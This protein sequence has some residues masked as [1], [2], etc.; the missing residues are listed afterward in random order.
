MD[1]F[2]LVPDVGVGLVEEGV[3]AGDTALRREM[4]ARGWCSGET[5][6]LPRAAKFQKLPRVRQFDDGSL[7]RLYL[8]VE[9]G[10]QLRH[11]HVRRVAVVEFRERQGKLRA[12]LSQRHRGPAGLREDKVGRLQHGGQI[13]HQSPRPVENDVA[14]HAG[15]LNENEERTKQIFRAV[16][17]MRIFMIPH[18]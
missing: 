16:G 9:P 14:D 18:S 13:V 15:N 6:A 2:A 7:R 8:R 4:V 3:E 12:E 11:R 1:F 17:A 5:S 10:L